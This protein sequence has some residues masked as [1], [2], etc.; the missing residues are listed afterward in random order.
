MKCQRCAKQVA[1]HV[2]EILGEGQIDELHLCEDCAK[3]YLFQTQSK[4]GVSSGSAT[5]PE[6]DPGDAVGQG[7][8]QCPECGLKFVEFRNGGRLGC[9]HDYDA[10]RED[11]VPLLESVH[12]EAKHVGKHPRHRPRPKTAHTELA[13]LRKKLQAAVSNEKYEEAAAL[14]DKIKT[15]ET[16]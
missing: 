8:R 10:F 7:Q 16:N 14:R 15:L 3:K 5:S 4:V 13:T 11:L 2:T 12:G 1:Y 6:L 9:P